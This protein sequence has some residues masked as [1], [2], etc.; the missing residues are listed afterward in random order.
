M[1]LT[2]ME[3][4]LSSFRANSATASRLA[5]TVWSEEWFEPAITRGTSTRPG[6]PGSK[7]VEA[8]RIRANAPGL[9]RGLRIVVSNRPRRIDF[10]YA[11]DEFPHL[12]VSPAMA[13]IAPSIRARL[14][15][16]HA[17]IRH[18]PWVWF[19][20]KVFLTAATKFLTICFRHGQGPSTVLP[21]RC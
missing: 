5:V 17:T 4:S 2:G 16:R 9:I 8:L 1:S 13:G 6:F 21:N 18:Y 20:P 7:W 3:Q 12:T 10:D 14:C 11:I 19:S 15:I